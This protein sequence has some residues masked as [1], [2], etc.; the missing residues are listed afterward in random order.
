[1]QGGI[2]FWLV[3]LGGEASRT[4]SATQRL[5]LTLTPELA[6]GKGPLRVSDAVPERPR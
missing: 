4:T 5:R 1:M 3:T 2:A 6:S